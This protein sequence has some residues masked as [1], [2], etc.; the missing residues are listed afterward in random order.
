[1]IELRIDE[2][3]E[4]HE[5]KEYS[6]ICVIRQFVDWYFDNYKRNLLRKITPLSIKASS[7]KGEST[8]N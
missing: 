4:L 1:M 3:Y 2:F 5:S 7:H 6:T 8:N